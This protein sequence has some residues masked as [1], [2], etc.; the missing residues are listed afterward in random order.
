VAC[1][2]RG[3]RPRQLYKALLIN[4]GKYRLTQLF[5][6]CLCVLLHSLCESLHSQ[7]SRERASETSS[8]WD[9]CMGRRAIKFLGSVILRDCSLLLDYFPRVLI[10][11]QLLLGGTHSCTTN[12]RLVRA[13]I[14]LL[15]A[16]SR[17]STCRLLPIELS[18]PLAL[19]LPPGTI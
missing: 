6:C 15:P 18:V 10:P 17:S 3:I 11:V 19:V 4:L 7:N 8:T 9:T 12:L 1:S 14:P 2:T 13:P 5:Y 16:T